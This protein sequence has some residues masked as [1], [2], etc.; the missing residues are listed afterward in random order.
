MLARKRKLLTLSAT[1]AIVILAAIFISTL[2]SNLIDVLRCPL[3][4]FSFLGGEINS[5]ASYRRISAQNQR[6][7]RQ[8][9]LN[10]RQLYESSELHL[11]NIRIRELLDFKQMSVYP[12]TATGV[13][14]YDPSNLSSIVLI[15]KG[16]Q[17]GITR[18]CA[19]I[20]NDGLVGRIIEAGDSVSKVL[21]VNDVN[22]G[23]AAFIQRSRHSGLVTGKLG[24]G[25]ILRYLSPDADIQV[26]D[27]VVTSGLGGLYPK[28][29]LIGK[30][31]R[32]LREENQ[33]EIFAVIESSADLNRLEELLVVIKK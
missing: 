22:S 24:G 26:S 31:T 5:I 2:R 3:Q 30:V 23:V 21:L 13:I 11:E 16:R 6:L 27:L 25:I 32:I 9:G 29:I 15:D 4:V 1:S 19:V 7:E 20:T 17:Q 10:Q 12:L 14:G 28:G 33:P 8:V 18:D